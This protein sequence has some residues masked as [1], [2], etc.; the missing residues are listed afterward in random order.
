MKIKCDYCGKEFECCPSRY[1]SKTHCCSKECMTNLTKERNLNCECL[2]CHRK[3]HRKPSQIN[4]NKTVYC[5][6]ECQKEDYKQRFF[7]ENNPN[8]NNRGQNNPIWKS[9]ERISSYGYKLIKCSNHPFANSDG[10]VFEHRLVAEKHLLTEEN[11]IDVD[12]K[13]YLSPKYVVHH[14][15]RN[16][17]NNSVENLLVLS[18]GDHQRLH[19]KEDANLLK[20]YLNRFVANKKKEH[21]KMN[22]F[23]KVNF[24][25]FK[26]AIQSL[27][28]D[29]SYTDKE[30]KNMFDNIKLPQRATTGSAGYDFVSPFNIKL[31]P[32]ETIIIPTG[33]GIV[34]DNN[35]YLLCCPRSGLGFKY[36]C[37]LDNTIGI[38]DSDYW[39]SD[40]DGHILAKITNDSLQPK[41]MLIEQ[42]KSFMQG[43]I[44]AY[45]LTDEDDEN[46]KEL[47]NGGFGST[48]K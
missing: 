40:N 13:R 11:S 42:G 20:D 10:F 41:T 44:S 37:Q 23:Y 9:N 3:L 36:R 25:I 21:T 7:G 32:Q 38:I 45:F 15:D 16:H 35:K 12:N 31:D 17:L 26:E 14:V 1:K 5:S 19:N 47:R 29:C 39:K 18:K 46:L 27:N 43:V 22:K 24:N 28:K 4:K 2:I 8:Y 34:L 48:G 33:I 30:I 6:R